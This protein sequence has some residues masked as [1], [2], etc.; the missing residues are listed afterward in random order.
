[1]YFQLQI[2]A[3]E[4]NL[5]LIELQKS[6]HF[7]ELNRGSQNRFCLLVAY[8]KTPPYILLYVLYVASEDFAVDINILL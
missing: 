4:E 7:R 5:R 3:A 6:L 1:M 8:H 2:H